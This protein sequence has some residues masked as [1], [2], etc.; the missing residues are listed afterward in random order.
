LLLRTHGEFRGIVKKTLRNLI[1]DDLDGYVSAQGKIDQDKRA[2]EGPK[3]ATRTTTAA[4]AAAI[5][6]SKGIDANI[7]PPFPLS[8]IKGPG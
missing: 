6:T 8:F 2:T 4:S 5:Q 3:V 1:V 7:A